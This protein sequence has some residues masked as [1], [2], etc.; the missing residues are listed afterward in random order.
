MRER[1]VKVTIDTDGQV[2]LGVS[3]DPG[4]GCLLLTKELE[5]ALGGPILERTKTSEYHETART[6]AH[7]TLRGP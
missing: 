1:T 3:G 5:E 6:T 2:Q 7:Q 4:P